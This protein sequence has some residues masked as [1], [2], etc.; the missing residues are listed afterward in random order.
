LLQRIETNRD[1]PLP[2]TATD[3]IQEFAQS[4][5]GR[6]PSTIRLYVAGAR[7]A[8][9]AVG[10]GVS[11]CGSR[12]ELLS[13]VQKGRP[14]KGA[15]VGPFLRFLERGSSAEGTVKESLE[16]IRGI[17]YWVVQTIAKRLRS[18]KN[19]S[20]ATRRDMALIAS[21]CCAPAELSPER[22]NPLKWPQSCLRIGSGEVFLWGQK[23]EE[24]A[25]ALS[26]RYWHAWRERLARGDQARLYRKNPG[27]SR[28]DL[29]FPGPRGG[30]LG[31]SALHNALRRL[32]RVGERSL[33]PQKVRAA[34]LASSGSLGAARG[35]D[36]LAPL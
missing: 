18:D 22:A 4:L 11:E 3:L 23:I 30:P 21:L 35:G 16:D 12:A 20:I 33:T 2:G 24:P 29:L 13:L 15:R 8:I 6:R 32:T 5:A 36:A 19:P 14:R 31:R 9:K 1:F 28:S 27:W 26:L 17:Q 34:F 25:F 7:A 10:A